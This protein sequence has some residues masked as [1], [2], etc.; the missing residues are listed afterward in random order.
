MSEARLQNNYDAIAFIGGFDVLHSDHK[1]FLENGVALASSV[2]SFDH[3]YLG[4][5]SN[6][7]LNQRKGETSPLFSFAWRREDLENWVATT[8]LEQDIKI[9]EAVPVIQQP[10]HRLVVISEEYRDSR[11]VRGAIDGGSHVLFVPPVNTLHTAD[12]KKHLLCAEKDSNCTER[13]IGAVLLRRGVIIDAGS[14]GGNFGSCYSCPKGIDKRRRSKEAG[15]PMPSPLECSF[16]HA[17]IKALAKAQSGD[18][19][20]ITV[21]PCP[22]C[23]E[24][25]VGKGINRVVYLKDWITGKP[26]TQGTIYLKR[27]GI[28]IRQAGYHPNSP[29]D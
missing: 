14:N 13:Q 22:P 10:P 15:R 3:V 19:L 12:I 5:D 16:A 20:L 29:N 26:E 23:A 9:E 8:P 4:V 18:D 7:I 17:E 2:A 6:V 28:R 27:H 1:T 25:I 21:S 11:I 24:A